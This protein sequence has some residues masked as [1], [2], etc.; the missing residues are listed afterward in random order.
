MAVC[1]DINGFTIYGEDRNFA[2]ARGVEVEEWLL[3]RHA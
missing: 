2:E 1:N 3:A